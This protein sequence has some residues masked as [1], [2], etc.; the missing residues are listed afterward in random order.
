[1]D[2]TD[3]QRD[4]LI[5]TAI[6]EARGEG[7]RGMEA[8][9]H[10]IF[11]RAN[12]GSGGFSSDPAEVALQK[13]GKGIYQFSAWNAADNEGNDPWQWT[14]DSKEYKAASEAL[15]AVLDAASDPTGGA[16]FYH[17]T[18][19]TPYWADET[20]KYGTIKIGNHKFYRSYLQPMPARPFG[21]Q[22]P[23][24]TPPSFKE[25]RQ[26]QNTEYASAPERPV[27]R[28]IQNQANIAKTR[29][30]PLDESLLT[31]L[32]KVGERHDV[33]FEVESGGQ[34][35]ETGYVNSVRHDHGMAADVKA[36][37]LDEAGNKHYITTDTPEGQELWQ[38]I[39]ARS[40]ALGATGVGMAE[41]YMGNDQMHIGFGNP[42]RIAGPNRPARPASNPNPLVWGV[43]EKSATA[44]GWLVQALKQGHELQKPPTPMPGRPAALRGGTLGTSGS[45]FALVPERPNGRYGPGQPQSG[46]PGMARGNLQSPFPLASD[47]SWDLSI[48]QP[49][50]RIDNGLMS[51]DRESYQPRPW[52]PSGDSSMPHAPAAPGWVTRTARTIALD[53][54]TEKPVLDRSLRRASPQPVMP[55]T[56]LPQLQTGLSPG[57][58][59][60]T[61]AIRPG[62]RLTAMAQG[63]GLDAGQLL[64]M[65]AHPADP[66]AVRAAE[67]LAFGRPMPSGRSQYTSPPVVRT[68]RTIRP[69]QRPRETFDQVWAEARDYF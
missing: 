61:F 58:L 44:P 8:V 64:A 5:R 12:S 3:Y 46:S 60:S 27:T 21:N 41:G 15:D 37:Q 55:R 52:L 68:V 7:K 54:L 67:A 42:E 65:Y 1:M 25:T 38:S 43:G 20:N 26:E 9:L 53:P 24:I 62:D 69:P 28:V 10:V 18:G 33:Y 32:H 17:T 31:L 36:Y 2:L 66:D 35:D 51:G 13:N 14:E 59:G 29:R 39:A 4:I 49:R 45:N 50:R 22:R 16:M 23:T 57:G 40:F 6:G 47:P 56:P 48:D 11:N 34:N 30:A 19:I 63:S